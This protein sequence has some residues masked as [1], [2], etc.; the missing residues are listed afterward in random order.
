MPLIPNLSFD[1]LRAADDSLSDHALISLAMYGP[2]DSP[3]FA[4]IWAPVDL[5][6]GDQVPVRKRTFELDWSTQSVSAHQEEKRYPML[7][8]IT[9]WEGDQPRSILVY[10]QFSKS[11]AAPDVVKTEDPA[12]FAQKFQ[13]G[14]VTGL[15]MCIQLSAK[16]PFEGDTPKE[17]Y[18]AVIHPAPKLATMFNVQRLQSVKDKLDGLDSFEQHRAALRGWSRGHHAI[19]FTKNVSGGRRQVAVHYQDDTFKK[20]PNTITE[21]SRCGTPIEGPIKSSQIH[22]RIEKGE[23][24]GYWPLRVG[25]NGFGEHTRFFIT[26]AP[27]G[28]LLPMKRY[29]VVVDGVDSAERRVMQ[30]RGYAVTGS[31]AEASSLSVGPAS[32]AGGPAT[33]PAG[34]GDGLLFGAAYHLAE[35]DKRVFASMHKQGAHAAQIAVAKDSKLKL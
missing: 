2:A 35:I 7:V 27:K 32:F 6:G 23:A 26:W 12:L 4:A 5:F 17:T 8:G 28:K 13:H 19:P 9:A 31:F 30:G 10:E 16:N 15:D 22:S 14:V 21:E 29:D 3:L 1:L 33:Q 11:A 25:A 18:V 34:A 20:W 24:K